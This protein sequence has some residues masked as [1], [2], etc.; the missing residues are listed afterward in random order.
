MI[1]D[2][3]SG[4]AMPVLERTAQ[5][6]AERHRVLAHNIA[7]LSTPH[8]KS[9]DLDPESFQASLRDAIDEPAATAGPCTFATPAS[10]TS[11]ATA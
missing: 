1:Q 3:F 8:F 11:T 4:G 10:S 6:T 7:N 9:T 2:L 5:F